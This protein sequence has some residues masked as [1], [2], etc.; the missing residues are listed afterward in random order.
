MT[1]QRCYLASVPPAK[2]ICI[3][4]TYYYNP[5]GMETG[6]RKV[7]STISAFRLQWRIKFFIVKLFFISYQAE[8]LTEEQQNSWKYFLSFLKQV[9]V[10][11]PCHS[12]SRSLSC[13]NREEI[14]LFSKIGRLLRV[15]DIKQNCSLLI[16]LS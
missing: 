11:D 7:I 10:T 2:N 1:S 13:L 5:I 12:K 15:I 3:N 14:I 9:P 8:M 16:A 4:T 6:T